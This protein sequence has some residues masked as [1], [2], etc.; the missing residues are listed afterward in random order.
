MDTVITNNLGT[1]IT[2]LLGG[3]VFALVVSLWF[4]CIL[5]LYLRRSSR[6]ERVEERLRLGETQK[7]EDER[8]LRLWRDGR[9]VTTNVPGKPK[10]RSLLVRLDQTRDALGWDVPIRTA[11]LGFI[12][13]ASSVCLVTLV[14]TG[15]VLMALGGTGLAIIMV[16]IYGKRRLNQQADLFER[17]LADALGL[18]TRSLQAGHPL[19]GAFRLIV[20][21][22]D[23]PIR[24][25]FAEI[26]QQQALGTSL[27]YAIRTTAEK[28]N[29][30]DMKLFAA[31]TIIQL[32]SGGN[33]ADMMHRVAEVIRDRIRL[34]KR[35]RVLTSQTQL[36]KRILIA[37]PFGLF[38]L[39]YILNPKYLEPLYT[40]PAGK[41]MLIIAGVCLAIGTW[42][43]NRLATLR[44]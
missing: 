17:Q 26:L 42:V 30:S 31:A 24:N 35:V 23:P 37:V 13:V 18:A 19:L 27:E 5:W 10:R 8:V 34:H 39:L 36:S 7:S 32:G 44:Y 1:E 25:L 43:M 16:W 12:G 28:T 2:W 9:E 20:E 33:L 6:Q 22:M 40:T 21:E 4:I 14:L 3:S 41:L 11:I 29:S 15:S 38:L